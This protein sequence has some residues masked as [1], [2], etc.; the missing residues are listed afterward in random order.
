FPADM[1]V[2]N[3][4][5]PQPAG[6]AFTIQNVSS[7]AQQQNN[8][9]RNGK[10]YN[11][12]IFDAALSATKAG[13]FV[14]DLNLSAVGLVRERPNPRVRNRRDPF[15]DPFGDPFG[16]PFANAFVR[17]KELALKTQA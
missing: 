14:P 9:V 16:D 13:S 15:A 3:P 1:T 11:V 10:R 12:L 2:R 5:K 4:G 17:Q 7:K 6:S 8:V